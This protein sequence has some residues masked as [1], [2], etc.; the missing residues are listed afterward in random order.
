MLLS[1]P[2]LQTT[3]VGLVV[4]LA[5]AII[6]CYLWRQNTRERYLVFWTAA[7]SAGALRWIIHFPAHTIPALRLAEGL[8]IP[9]T[10]LLAVLGSYDLL[11]AKPWKRRHVVVGTGA[12]LLAYGAAANALRM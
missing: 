1:N 10:M 8:L 6:A 2:E 3:I 7:W 4:N 11:P 9:V 12:I 5:G